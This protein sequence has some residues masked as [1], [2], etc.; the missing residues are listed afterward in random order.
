MRKIVLFLSIVMI[1]GP[2]FSGEPKF[3]AKTNNIYLCDSL[4]TSYTTTTSSSYSF[5]SYSYSSYCYTYG[6]LYWSYW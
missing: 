4:K 5:S 3:D 2:L 6:Y 1:G